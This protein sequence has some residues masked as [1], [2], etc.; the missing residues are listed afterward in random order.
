M[1]ST[2]FFSPVMRKYMVLIAVVL[3]GAAPP[4]S[5]IELQSATLTA[6]QDYA[7]GARVRMQSRLDA[8]DSFLWIDESPDRAGRV[9]R[10]ETVVAPLL[11]NGIRTVPHGVIHHWIGAVFVPG[12]TMKSFLAVVDDYDRYREIYKPV[13]ADSKSLVTNGN[14]QAFSMIWQRRVLFIDAA[15][16]GWFQAHEGFVDSSRGYSIVDATRLQQIEHYRHA[17]ERFLPPDTGD[18]FIWRI[19]SITRFEQRDGGVYFEIEAMSLTRD[20][21]A[22]LQ[23]LVAPAIKRL[24]V[25]SLMTTVEKTRKAVSA[26]SV[27]V[28]MRAGQGQK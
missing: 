22:S 23:W 26:Q 12:A 10:G 13:V 25:N 18:G 21:P 8:K 3:L 28:A 11:D 2:N 4:A 16:Q 19:Q 27:A 17:S 1:A 14:N 15:I 7:Q 6:W 9:R 20:I 5:A 24:S